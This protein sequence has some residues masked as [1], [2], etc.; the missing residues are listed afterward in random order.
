MASQQLFPAGG[1]ARAIIFMVVAMSMI[2]LM[3][4][5]VKY[6][7]PDYPTNQI[8]W[9][10][11]AGHL[12][13]VLIIFLP[14]HGLAMLKAQ[15]PAVHIVRSTMMFISTCCFFFSLRYIE[16]P[17]AS[18]INFTSPLIVT[19]LAIPMLGEKVGVRRWSAVAVG[20]IGALII[21]RPGG[22]NTHW[23][24]LVVLMSSLAYAAYQVM[25]RKYATVDS[26][27]TSVL[28]MALV[29]TVAL[30]VALPFNYV[31]PDN[32]FDVGLFGLIGLI[33][34]AAHFLIIHAFRI[35]EVSVL[36]TFNYTQLVM[37]TLASY[38]VFDT[39][40]DGYTFLGAAIII[41][42]GL[43]ITYR[44]TRLKKLS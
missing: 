17:V 34:G 14:H 37:A 27:E 19:A 33:G 16:V 43:Y 20:F 3:N 11:Y 10:R 31:I 6:L 4:I 32:W 21:I 1:L 36:S 2:P 24:M 38:L 12:L 40:P 15:R 25:T 13:F 29:G 22:D 5:S 42:S 35:G 44:E 30:S 8:V 41:T 9:A 39:F 7:S 18:A 28:Y 23:A 26:P